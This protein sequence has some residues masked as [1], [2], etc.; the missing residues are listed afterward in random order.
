MKDRVEKSA[1]YFKSGYNCCQS[2]AL[3]FAD[4]YNI[5]EDQIKLITSVFGGGIGKMNLTCGA[6]CGMFILAGLK[7]GSLDPKDATKKAENYKIVQ[8]LARKFI[9]E[10]GSMDCGELLGLK[11]RYAADGTQLE[12]LPKTPCSEK[13]A[14]ASRIFA[15]YLE[16]EP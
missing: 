14:S 8:E 13:V 7:N 11:K 2:V 15:S 5:D 10:N 16:Q 9:Q 6:A 1:E 4:L 12:A 3:A